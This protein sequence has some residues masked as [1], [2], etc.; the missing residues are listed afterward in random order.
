MSQ[1]VILPAITV[2]HCWLAVPF[3]AQIRREG[4]NLYVTLPEAM[5]TIFTVLKE[6]E[7]WLKYEL[8]VSQ[9]PVTVFLFAHSQ[10]SFAQTVGG[11]FLEVFHTYE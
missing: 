7:G 3:Y 1:P 5:R 11:A 6:E 4:E 2:A 8:T 9:R 10:R